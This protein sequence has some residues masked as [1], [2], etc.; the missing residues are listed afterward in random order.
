MQ[1]KFPFFLLLLMCVCFSAC[2]KEI[3][4]IPDA[5]ICLRNST[6]YYQ[7][8][9][10]AIY[11]RI[12]NS[13]TGA[14]KKTVIIP[15]Y[16]Y[17]NINFN[18]TY[19]L[20]G[21]TEPA[22]GKWSVDENCNFVLKPLKGTQHTYQ[23]KKLTPD[24][25][26]IAERV[27]AITTTLHFSTFN[28]PDMNNLEARWDNV[29]TRTVD[30]DATGVSNRQIN[31]PTGYIRFNTDAGYELV[32]NGFPFKGTWGIAQPD[33]NLILDKGKRWE[34]SYIVEKL[35]ADSLKLWY[36]DT[37][38]KTNYLLVYKKH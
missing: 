23:V 12:D 26:I 18:S 11:T 4:A 9:W 25:L 3:K 14:A 10:A 36:K 27:G 38:A 30:Y 22:E 7:K 37:V 24:S 21:D 29:E 35:T 5:D 6:L 34:K 13:E 1:R 31:Y 32:S 28:C 33:C 20:F 15:A 8:K 17:F 16:G 2:K 19:K